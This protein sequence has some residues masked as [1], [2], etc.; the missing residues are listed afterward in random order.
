[1]AALADLAV[2]ADPEVVAQPIVEEARQVP[3]AHPGILALQDLREPQERPVK[4]SPR[5][6][7]TEHDARSEPPRYTP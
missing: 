4:S 2:R 1:L 7:V 3:A 6:R 5:H